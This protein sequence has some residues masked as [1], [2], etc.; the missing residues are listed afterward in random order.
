MFQEGTVMKQEGKKKAKFGED[1]GERER[2][3]ERETK[4]S[5]RRVA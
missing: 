3:R 4:G 5:F 2:E 1:R